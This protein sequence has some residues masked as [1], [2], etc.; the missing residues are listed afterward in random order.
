MTSALASSRVDPTHTPLD[1]TL[2]EHNWTQRV[3]TT[4]ELPKTC[5]F[6]QR[7]IRT[8]DCQHN[9]RRQLWVWFWVRPTLEQFI[10]NLV[11]AKPLWSSV[12]TVANIGL[13]LSWAARVF[14]RVSNTEGVG[15]SFSHVWSACLCD[16]PRKMSYARRPERSLSSNR[17]RPPRTN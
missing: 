8:S 14:D 11:G 16:R 10:S 3:S 12:Q 17:P 5:S 1:K 2:R 15:T 7:E 4:G 13:G 6:T 9:F